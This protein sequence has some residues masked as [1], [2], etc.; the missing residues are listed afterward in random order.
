MATAKHKGDIDFP[1]MKH[2]CRE[3]S[4]MFER[5][6]LTNIQSP[7]S[8]EQ[9]A[10]TNVCVTMPKLL[11]IPVGSPS[12]NIISRSTELGCNYHEVWYGEEGGVGL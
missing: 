10:P 6:G 5:Q 8:A 11:Q 2:T 1:L 3:R 9:G 12:N 7:H 4:A